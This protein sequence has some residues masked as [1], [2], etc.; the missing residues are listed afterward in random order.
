MYI[1]RKLP[2]KD[3]M[4][5]LAMPVPTTSTSIITTAAPQ[6]EATTKPIEVYT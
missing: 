5:T 6:P 3:S 2:H 4:K 1:G